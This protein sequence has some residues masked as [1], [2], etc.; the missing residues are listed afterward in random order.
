MQSK[1]TTVQAYLRSPPEDRRAAISA[2]RDMILKNL[3]PSYE[4][5]M[6]YGMI[7]YYVPHSV[8]PK[9]YHSNPKQPLTFAALGSQKNYMSVYLM[10]VYGGAGGESAASKNAQWFRDEW[11]KSGKKLDMGKSCIR[12]RKLDDL[13]LDLIGEAVKRVPASSYIQAC[14]ASLAGTKKRAPKKPDATQER[15]RRSA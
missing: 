10:C 15:K 12:F 1:A 4:E 3:D 14:E 6:Q 8:Y 11:A 5:G 13:P 9:G 7:G 2:V